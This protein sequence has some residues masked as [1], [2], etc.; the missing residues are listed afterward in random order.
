MR[1]C[2]GLLVARGNVFDF[3]EIETGGRIEI[4]E[5]L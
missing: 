3:D 2:P 1:Y 5:V 4:I